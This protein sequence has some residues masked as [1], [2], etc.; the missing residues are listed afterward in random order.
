MMVEEMSTR[1]IALELTSMYD[2]S[3]LRGLDVN[4]EAK[5][6]G[7]TLGIMTEAIKMALRFLAEDYY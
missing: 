5:R 7:V 1:E 2:T 3:E 4:A 6:I